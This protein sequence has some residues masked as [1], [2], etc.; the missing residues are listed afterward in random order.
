[1][2]SIIKKVIILS[3]FFPQPIKSMAWGMTG[4]RIVGEIAES[5]LTPNAKKEVLK[6]LGTQSLAMASNW[7]DFIKSDSTYDSLYN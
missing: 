7:A 1:M 6:I 3:L 2:V 4:H 5:Y